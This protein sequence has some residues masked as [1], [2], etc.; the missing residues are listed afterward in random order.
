MTRRSPRRSSA[1]MKEEEGRKIQRRESCSGSSLI[2]DHLLM[3]FIFMILSFWAFNQMR[4]SNE[5]ADPSYERLE[6][7]AAS[8]RRHHDLVRGWA[9]RKGE[10]VSNT[11]KDATFGIIVLDALMIPRS[12]SS[13]AIT[14]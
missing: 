6:R 2:C 10:T 8:P 13:P 3:F 4:V 9:Q 1:P 12:S 5:E 14:T 11:D 7:S